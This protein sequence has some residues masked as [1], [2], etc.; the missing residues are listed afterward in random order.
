M[1]AN[2][3]GI[4]VYRS[5]ASI[6][7]NKFTAIELRFRFEALKQIIMKAEIKLIT[8]QL[9][10]EMLGHNTQNRALKRMSEVICDLMIKGEWKENGE[11]IVFSW[12]GVLRDG[13][14]RLNATIKA[15]HSWRCVVV[16]GVDPSAYD[17]YDE[18]TNRQL[19]DVLQID[20]IKNSNNVASIIKR[21]NLYNKG[22]S[23]SNGGH[24]SS[25]GRN[26]S[27]AFGRSLVNE[28]NDELQHLHRVSISIY[29]AQTIKVFTQTDIALFLYVTSKGFNIT[30]NQIEFVNRIC[31]IEINDYGSNYI[32][33][34]AVKS[35]ES[36]TKINKSYLLGLVIKA[37]NNYTLGDPSV[38]YF[39][40]DV[41]NGLPKVESI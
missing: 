35:K 18:G 33:K 14:H 11:S 20:G 1:N 21:I 38:N 36:K 31:G 32:Y 7:R 6:G 26:M 41:K 16:T 3:I 29:K 17:T 5:L 39:R 30:E 2:F 12:D 23:I 19:S 10:K 15:N 8:P 27:N 4:A 9:A 37:W 34:M 22:L 24:K 28:S 40:F 25:I 13:Q